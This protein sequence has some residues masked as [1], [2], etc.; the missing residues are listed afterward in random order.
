[1]PYQKLCTPFR[2]PAD[3][4]SEMWCI[5]ISESLSKNVKGMCICPPK[6]CSSVD[7]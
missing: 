4:V 6:M 3:F 2:I 1:M 7:R 5:T